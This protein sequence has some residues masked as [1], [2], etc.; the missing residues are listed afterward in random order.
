MKINKTYKPLPCEVCKACARST[1]PMYD[2]GEVYCKKYEK[3]ASHYGENFPHINHPVY[4]RL[5]NICKCECADK[6]VSK[7]RMFIFNIRKYFREI[8]DK[9]WDR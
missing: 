7:W 4:A 9:H 8:D 5:Y 2:S 6:Y 3:S 1:N